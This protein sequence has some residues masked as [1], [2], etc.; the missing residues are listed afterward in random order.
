MLAHLY[1]GEMYR[2]KVWR[3]RLDA[4]TNWA[5]VTTGVAVSVSFSSPGSSPLP[6]VLVVLLDLVFLAMEARRYRYFDIWRT[7]VRMME[8]SL[9]GPLLRLKGVRVDDAWN[10]TLALD[11]EEPHFNISMWEA[12]GRRLRRNYSFLFLIQGVSYVAKICIHPTPVTALEQL[13]ARAAVGPVPGEIV[14]I[15]GFV[16]HTGLIALALLTL[17]GQLAAGRVKKRGARA[18]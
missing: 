13:F 5:V 15:I 12:V 1:R 4:T 8:V 18:R 2:S 14:L 6:L 10:E 16:F 11:Y 9:Y 7:R 17:R 3:T